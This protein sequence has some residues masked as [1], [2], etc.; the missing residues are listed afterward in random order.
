MTSTTPLCLVGVL[1]SDLAV[2][3]LVLLC[4]SFGFQALLVGLLIVLMSIILCVLLCFTLRVVTARFDCLLL[5]VDF[6][7]LR[8]GMLVDC[9]IAW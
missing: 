1:V 3:L 7:L 5:L 8:L 2:C 6:G 4:C 9:R